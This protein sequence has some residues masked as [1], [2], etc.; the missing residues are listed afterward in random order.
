MSQSAVKV[1]IH[2]GLVALAQKFGVNRMTDDLINRLAVNAKPVSADAM[3]WLFLRHATGGVVAGLA[4]MLLFL[5][6]RHDLS[7]AMTTVSFWT[8]FF[9]GIFLLLILVPAVLSY[10]DRSEA[11]RTGDR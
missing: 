10:L 9:Y 11:S 4:I 8:K 7:L 3:R 2:R 6:I 1:A 5:G